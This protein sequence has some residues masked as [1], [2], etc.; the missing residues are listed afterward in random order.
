MAEKIVVNSSYTE[1]SEHKNYL[2]LVNLVSYYNYPNGNGTQIDYGTTDEEKAATLE[3][4]KTMEFIPS[5]TDFAI[6]VL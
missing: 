1:L 6:R 4:A 3:R 5:R 2:E